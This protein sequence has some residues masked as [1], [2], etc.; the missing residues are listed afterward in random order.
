MGTEV[1]QANIYGR[2]HVIYITGHIT[3]LSRHLPKTL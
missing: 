3:N 1:L 2:M